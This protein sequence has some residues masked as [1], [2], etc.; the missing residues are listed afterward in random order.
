MINMFIFSFLG[1]IG[2][3][4]IGVLFSIFGSKINKK[5]IKFLK[6]FTFGSIVALLISGILKES[7]EAF[8]ELS[9]NLSLLFTL[10]VIL[11][12]LI[13]FYFVHFIFDIKHHHS[14]SDIECEDHDFHFHENKSLLVTA[15]LFLVSIS[16]HNIPEGL[17]LGSS[18]LGDETYGILLSI[19]VFGLHN[20][21]IGYA[22]CESFLKAHINKRKAAILT[23]TSAVVAYL[24]AIG[25]YFLGNIGPL[26][27]AILLSVSAGAMIYI[28]LKE[29]LPG[30]IKNYDIYAAISSIL[31][32]V[33]TILIFIIH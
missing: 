13:I 2:F 32:L 26:F 4:I 29:L 12:V 3:S 22:I 28:I 25:G 30:I 31:G 24:S 7:L 8:S 21:V 16:L 20:F 10:L 9:E 14:H 19:V 27:E 23:L 1:T 6:G 18:F 5:F 17:A 15:L 11:V 33:I